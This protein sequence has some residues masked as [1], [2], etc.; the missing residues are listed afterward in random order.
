MTQSPRWTVRKQDSTEH[1]FESLEHVKKTVE[2][3]EFGPDDALRSPGSE[4]WEA[5]KDVEALQALLPDADADVIALDDADV[6]A[7]DDDAQTQI[8]T[9][10]SA[11]EDPIIEITSIDESDL[12]DDYTSVAQIPEEDAREERSSVAPLSSVK[13][14]APET[15]IDQEERSS[16]WEWV[17]LVAVLGLIVL[18]AMSWNDILGALGIDNDNSDTT[19]DIAS[20]NS[21]FDDTDEDDLAD[22]DEATEAD[23]DDTAVAANAADNEAADTTPV[24]QEERAKPAASAQA[25]SKTAAVQPKP[26][27]KRAK[28]GSQ[29]GARI[30]PTSAARLQTVS[31]TRSKAQPAK[32]GIDADQYLDRADTALERSRTQEAYLYYDKVRDADKANAKALTGIGF[33]ALNKGKYDV[34]ADY[35]RKAV[36]AGD[37]EGLIGLGQVYRE[38]NRDARALKVYNLYLKREPNSRQ[39]SIARYQRKFIQK[40]MATE[41]ELQAEE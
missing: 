11:D 27:A 9:A 38:T 4:T 3:G 33:V 26:A 22:E 25:T 30:R 10:A 1:H 23:A 12:D 14:H 39:A 16:S 32:R 20:D 31:A 2:L 28:V 15:K 40:R 5:I 34:A 13:P 21:L 37:N 24:A 6:E 36:R 35:F 17:A 7:H 8:H 29:M 18:V 41:K 19:E